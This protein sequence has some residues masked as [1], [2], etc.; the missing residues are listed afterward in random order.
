[1]H[2]SAYALWIARDPAISSLEE[3]KMIY[4]DGSVQVQITEEMSS[5]RLRLDEDRIKKTKISEQFALFLKNYLFDVP[6]ITGNVNF[7]YPRLTPNINLGDAAHPS[8]DPLLCSRFPPVEVPF[9]TTG[10]IN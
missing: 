5:P 8:W 2:Q 6:L 10:N 7:T 3:I 4:P 1:M 9:H